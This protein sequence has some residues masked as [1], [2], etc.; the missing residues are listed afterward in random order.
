MVFSL[1]SVHGLGRQP[2]VSKLL[3]ACLQLVS[4][5]LVSDGKG[6]HKSWLR[7]LSRG[8]QGKRRDSVVVSF[9]V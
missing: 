2:A 3:L 9:K 8:L 5:Q 1:W 4:Y 7:S 6:R